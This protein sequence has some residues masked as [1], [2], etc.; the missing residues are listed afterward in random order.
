MGIMN[1]LEQKENPGLM[2]T[3]YDDPN[4]MELTVKRWER[5][6]DEIWNEF[7]SAS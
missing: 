5:E 3:S 4:M 1:Y 6:C 2:P 7:S